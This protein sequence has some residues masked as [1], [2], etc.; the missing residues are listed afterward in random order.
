MWLLDTDHLTILE[1]GGSPALSLQMRLDKVTVDEIGA[2]IVNYEEQMHGW[3]F[4]SA[5]ASTPAQLQ[6]AYALL[7]DYMATF[8]ALTVLP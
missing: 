7:E 3:L 8:G 6:K 5:Q 1:H 4:Q 2:T